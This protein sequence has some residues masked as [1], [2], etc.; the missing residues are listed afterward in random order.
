VHRDDVVFTVYDSELETFRSVRDKWNE[1]FWQGRF[2]IDYSRQRKRHVSH[3]P[4]RDR[5]PDPLRG[6]ALWL[7]APRRRAMVAFECWRLS[8][9][10]NAART[11][12]ERLQSIVLSAKLRRELWDAAGRR[13]TVVPPD[14]VF[15]PAIDINENDVLVVAGTGWL[16]IRPTLY[17]DLK[18]RYRN[19]LVFLCHDVIPLLFPQLYD[20]RTVDMFREYIHAIMPIADLVIFNSHRSEQDTREYCVANSLPIGKTRVM[21][22]GTKFICPSTAVVRPLPSGLETDHYALYVSNFDK[23]KGHAL[24]FSIWKRLLAQGVPQAHRFKLVFVGHRESGNMLLDEIESHPSVGGSLLILSSIGDDTLA[25]LYQQA[26]FCLFP[27]L[28][29]GYGLPVIEAFSYGKAV[30]A[31]TGGAL[32][33]VVGDLSPCLDPFD[34]QAWFETIKLW[35]EQ[36]AARLPFEAAIR[37][38]F[39]PIKWQEAAQEFFHLLDAELE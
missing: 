19:R 29:E 2:D 3:V 9:K 12:I 30:L 27:S 21:Q 25:T 6:L 7:H 18:K 14:L 15:G 11:C 22:F 37:E 8:V 35:I 31:S 26:A 1:I 39:R 24:L 32:P 28:Y 16:N 34:E 36:P 20:N 38:L 13:R 17:V 23:R 10:S 33:E 4:W 5:L